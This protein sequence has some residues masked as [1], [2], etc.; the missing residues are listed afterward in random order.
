MSSYPFTFAIEYSFNIF[1]A[2]PLRIGQYKT[3]TAEYG[4]R[5]TD[6]V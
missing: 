2:S 5:T 6:W 3:G 1:C 4:L